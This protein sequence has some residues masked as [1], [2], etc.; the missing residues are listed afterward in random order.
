VIGSDRWTV[1]DTSGSRSASALF[2]RAADYLDELG[3]VCVQDLVLQEESTAEG[4]RLALT[5]YFDRSRMKVD[6][7]YLDPRL[8]V[9]YEADSTHGPDTEF[10]MSL[11]TEL[12]ART[13]LDL[14]CGTGHLTRSL[15]TDR[16][17]VVGI[18]PS[19][20]MLDVARNQ[21]GAERVQWMIGDAGALGAPDADLVIMTG[22]V[23]QVF[24]EDAEWEE[25]LRGIHAALRAGGYLA[26]GS[27]NPEHRAWEQWNG[28]VRREESPVGAIDIS[29]KVV[30]VE[31]GRVRVVG[32]VV[33]VAAG[34]TLDA[35]S[36]YRFRTV[37]EL[38]DSLVHAG[39]H[40]EHTYGD[41]E[42]GPISNAS[43]E[44]VMVARRA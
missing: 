22:N 38:T 26:F 43:P 5:V 4:S 29:M 24:V 15:A 28:T 27:R 30:D 6:L 12:D 9:L 44:I 40:I 34:E 2:R 31:G 35:S 1:T 25:A 37:A 13:I 17:R 16:R 11:A 20:A 7:D 19:H 21:P 3:P 32:H 10:M 36:E 18:D 8:A 42:R 41:W 23:A 33:F 39:F 14:G